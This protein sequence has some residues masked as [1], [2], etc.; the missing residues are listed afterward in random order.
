MRKRSTGFAPLSE[1]QPPDFLIV[2]LL[3]IAALAQAAA[4]A[5]AIVLVQI[6]VRVVPMTLIA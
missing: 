6:G 1:I 4:V 2:L 3:L 5:A